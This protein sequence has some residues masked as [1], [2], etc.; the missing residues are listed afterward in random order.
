MI[1]ILIVNDEFGPR[2][3]ARLCLSRRSRRIQTAGSNEEALS[4]RQGES[5]ELL[6]TDLVHPIKDGGEAS[7]SREDDVDPDFDSYA[8]V[9]LIED[10]KQA[11]PR[12]K[13]V[14]ATATP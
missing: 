1:R 7:V 11:Y 4:L 5:F 8:G 14:V 12:I 3:S 2:E 10:V 13:I 6:I 9:E